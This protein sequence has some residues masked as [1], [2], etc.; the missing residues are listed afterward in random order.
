MIG[1]DYRLFYVQVVIE[2][3]LQAKYTTVVDL[4]VTYT[5]P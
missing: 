1:D 2:V 5:T 3:A 4:Q